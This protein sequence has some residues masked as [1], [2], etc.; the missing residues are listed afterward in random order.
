MATLAALLKSRGHD[1][2]GSDQNVYPPMSDFLV[3]QGITTCQGYR[4]ENITPDLDLV[5]V[6]NAIS[7][8]NAELEAVLAHEIGHYKK[9]HIMKLVGMSVLSLLAGFWLIAWLAQQPWFYAAF[10]F[11]PQS[12]FS[13]VAITPALLLFSLLSS[14]AT[15]WLAPLM[16]A[17]SRRYEYQADRYARDAMNEPESL[18]GALRKLT[19]KNLSNLTPHPLYSGFHYSHPTLVEREQALRR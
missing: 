4:A 9:R 7:R 6:G 19:E 15:F 1:V 8:G 17:W 12:G 18:I 10:G 14:A 16:N 2:R 5:V 11:E 3:E 13:P